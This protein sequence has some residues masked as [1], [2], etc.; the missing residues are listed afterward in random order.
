ML[1]WLAATPAPVLASFHAA[2]AV[3][4]PGRSLWRLAPRNSLLSDSEFFQQSDGITTNVKEMLEVRRAWALIFNYR[5]ENEGIYSRRLGENGLDLVLTFE[6]QEDAD[7]YI[8]M[9]IAQDFPEATSV[10]VDM[11]ELLDFCMQNGYQLGMA[12][13]NSVIV[14]P[15]ENVQRF[16]W[17]PGASEE[18]MHRDE[19]AE[20]QAQ[21]RFLEERW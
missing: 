1:L 7:R 16:D 21:R 12:R 8:N 4:A 3:C 5:S 19:T 13:S 11:A 2:A 20:L 15:A 14:P 10:Q 6:I 17:S 9:L 18:G